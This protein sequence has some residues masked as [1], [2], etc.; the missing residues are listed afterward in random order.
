MVKSGWRQKVYLKLYDLKDK[1]AIITGSC[2]GIGLEIAKTFKK[3][4]ARVIMTY[5]DKDIDQAN[6]SL[7]LIE[8]Y[9]FDLRVGIDVTDSKSV[10]NCFQKVWKEFGTINVLVNGARINIDS[11][12]DKIND[13]MWQQVINCN[14]KGPFICMREIYKYLSDRGKVINLGS[15]AGQFGGPR[16]TSHACAAAGV[17][18]LTH[19]YA[20]YAG[21][22][23]NVSVNC[24]SPGPIDGDALSLNQEKVHS[25]MEEDLL[26]KRLGTK[27]EV[28]DLISFLASD[29]SSFITGQTIG[30]NGG[31]WV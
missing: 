14:L 6:K 21:P 24:V 11:D 12:F 7:E 2:T 19:C 20:R 17:M 10:A 15:V 3:Y 18:A 9:K 26:I 30:I 8:K 31:I 29:N 1:V 22:R 13:E 27:Q 25:D 5:F 23:K 16:T 4:N 28:A